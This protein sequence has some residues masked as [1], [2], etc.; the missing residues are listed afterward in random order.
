MQDHVLRKSK[1]VDTPVGKMS[2]QGASDK[3]ARAPSYDASVSPL[4]V[5][6]LKPS[7]TKPLVIGPPASKA[8]PKSAK[9]AESKSLYHA[10]SPELLSVSPLQ[11]SPSMVLL[12]KTAEVL[13]SGGDKAAQSF[14]R[15]PVQTTTQVFEVR[16]TS[17]PG[18]P[19]SISRQESLLAVFKPATDEEDSL[20]V[21]AEGSF[22]F[23]AEERALR[24]RAAYVLD[25]TYHSF[26]RVPATA[27]ARVQNNN[28][29]LQEFIRSN[30]TAEDNPELVGRARAEEVQRIAILDCRIMNLDRHGGN[31]LVSRDVREK[32]RSLE[33]DSGFIIGASLTGA[34]E[35][36]TITLTPIDHSLSLPPWKNL[37]EA[38]FDWAY[39]PQADEP[40]TEATREVVSSL[41]VSKDQKELLDLGIHPESVATNRICTVALQ[42]LVRD[43][44]G[45][46]LKSLAEFYQRPYSKGHK[47]HHIESPLEHLVEEACRRSGMPKRENVTP[48]EGFFEA[49]EAVLAEQ[50]GSGAWR[51]FVV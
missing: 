30:G 9:T 16:K 38:W 49:F 19:S 4:Q 6:S 40:L 33:E 20:L 41:K 5:P 47:L 44:P 13:L 2:R 17:I 42:A 50:I 32:S 48:S 31:V 1:S 45:I 18:P 36:E 12:N 7:A 46:T 26:S 27:L 51:S 11:P 29:S 25:K 24:E 22:R 21:H 15:M 3:L 39:W 34:E 14:R 37:G 35:D 10:I 23:S 8:A 28:G 43:S